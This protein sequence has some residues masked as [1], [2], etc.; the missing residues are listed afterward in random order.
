MTWIVPEIASF[1]SPGAERRYL[2]TSQRS[3]TPRPPTFTDDELRSIMQPTYV[4]PASHS[5][6]LRATR[7]R[8]RRLR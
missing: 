5:E 3:A 4:Q 2:A 7:A 8:D 6:V 1:R